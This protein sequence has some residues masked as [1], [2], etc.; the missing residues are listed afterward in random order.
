MNGILAIDKPNGLTSHDVIAILR[1]LSG[2]RDIGHAGTLD[3]MAT[4]LLLVCLGTATRLSSFLMDGDKWYLGSI[5]FGTSTDT[6]DALGKPLTVSPIRCAKDDVRGALSA[7]IGSTMQIPPAYAAIKRDG[8]AAY[9]SARA[10]IVMEMAPRRIVVHEIHLL[11]FRAFDQPA[12]T[13][14][15][16]RTTCQADVLIRCGKGT[17][18]R[19]IAR[20]VGTAVGTGAHLS[21]LRRLASGMFTTA[22]SISI[23]ALSVEARAAGPSA[24]EARLWRP[25]RAASALKATVVSD[26][27]ARDVGIGRTFNIAGSLQDAAARVY[28]AGGQFLALASIDPRNAVLSTVQPRKVFTHAGAR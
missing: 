28:G 5:A 12:V 18:V 19:A 25:D 26:S 14:A 17:Y 4:G 13:N 23:D 1:R 15:G 7:L 27:V 20:D 24:L 22:D 2:Q 10:G 3:P 9:K 6:D 11:T 8:V 16:I 21:A